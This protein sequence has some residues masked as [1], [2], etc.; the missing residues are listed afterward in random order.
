MLTNQ[1]EDLRE[2]LLFTFLNGQSGG[3]LTSPSLPRVTAAV[4][5]ILAFCQKRPRREEELLLF[6][7]RVR[8]SDP[9]PLSFFCPVKYYLT[10][11]GF[12]GILVGSQPPHRSLRA[13]LGARHCVISLKRP[14]PHGLPREYL[15]FSHPSLYRTWLGFLARGLHCDNQT[16]LRL[17]NYN[18]ISRISLILR[19][20][21]LAHKSEAPFLWPRISPCCRSS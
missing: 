11:L 17:R 9:P 14:F 15:A 2:R 13:D 19:H 18:P 6:S 16:S 8:D 21:C 7:V 3:R 4:A 20:W 10:P 12:R 1:E 5:A